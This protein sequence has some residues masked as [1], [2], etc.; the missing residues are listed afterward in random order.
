MTHR[1][2]TTQDEAYLSAGVGGNGGVGIGHRWEQSA[3]EILHVADQIQ[4]QPGTFTCNTGKHLG[5]YKNH[6]GRREN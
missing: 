2:E 1:I 5:R 3:A 6:E 4:V